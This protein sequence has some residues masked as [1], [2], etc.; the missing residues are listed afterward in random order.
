[1]AGVFSVFNIGTGHTKDE[2]NNTMAELY[3]SCSDMGCWVNNGPLGVMG[4][5]GGQGMDAMCRE[6]VRAVLLSQPTVLN[7]AG[8]SRGG[9]LSHMIAND[10]AASE[11]STVS[12]VNIIVLDPV[13]MSGHVQ[14]GKQLRGTL[15]GHYVSIVM[16][17]V[18]Q[19]HFPLTDVKVLE[20][21]LRARKYVVNMP[22][23]HGSGTQCHTSPIGR[24]VYAFIVWTM[25]QW[26]TKFDDPVPT[27]KDLAEA[28][29]RIHVEAPV[30]YDDKG[31]V[32]K[33]LISDD[34]K[35]H[36]RPSE[37]GM[38]FQSVGRVK[39]IS[40]MFEEM[41]HAQ[42]NR[43]VTDF[44]NT[45][46]F[47]NEVHAACFRSAFPAL[48]ARFDGNFQNQTQVNAEL[49][50]IMVNWPFIERSFEQLGMI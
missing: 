41:S 12:Q 48:Y 23:T 28:F 47:F 25:S 6:T 35:G 34:K 38:S 45:P 42:G 27:M 13:N 32:K 44:R 9:V 3:R 43:T 4:A 37:F 20:D 7:I 31:L 40:Q 30:Q 16:E 19:A 1:M 22:G 26:G 36:M 39:Q 5:I 24:A 14:K 46:Y 33:R 8:H 15:I 11:E 18:T 10:V 17:N 29:A 50:D 21:Q 49:R 2:P